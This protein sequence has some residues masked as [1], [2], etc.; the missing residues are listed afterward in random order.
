MQSETAPRKSDKRIAT[1]HFLASGMRTMRILFADDHPL[2]AEALQIVIERSI[3]ESTLTI[4]GDLDSA[5]RALTG[6]ERFDLCIMD[7]HMPGTDGFVGIERTLAQFPET[8]L[9]V[10]SGSASTADVERAVALGAKG[11]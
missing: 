5:H 10:I 7:L 1:G 8:P 9:V 3:P 4:V 6:P 2:F 11:F